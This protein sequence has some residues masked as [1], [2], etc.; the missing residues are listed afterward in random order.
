MNYLIIGLAG[1]MGVGKNYI[2]DE[3]HKILEKKGIHV[4]K[5]AFADQ[6]KIN[7]ICKYNIPFNEVYTG[8]KNNKIRTLLQKTGTEEGRDVYGENIW[9]NYIDTWIKVLAKGSLNKIVFI[10][11]D[12]RFKNEADYI[13][14]NQG[15]VINIIAPLRNKN[16]LMTEKSDANHL[17]E[18]DLDDYKTFDYIIRNDIDDKYSLI[19]DI[20][21]INDIIK[22]L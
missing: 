10:I 17:S 11:T 16:R 20:I 7:C 2:A 5:I 18:I 14:K 21:I 6:L 22:G 1:K 12:V 9:I 4:I 15:K 19:D 3:L 8:E 13:K